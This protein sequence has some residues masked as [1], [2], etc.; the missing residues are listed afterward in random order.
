MLKARADAAL[1]DVRSRPEWSFVG[2]CDL[3]SLG[4][5][6]A[7]IAWQHWTERGMVRNES[8]ATE[9]SALGVDKDAPVIFIC[10]SGARSRAAAEAMHALGWRHCYN[11]SGGFEGDRDAVKHRGK[12]GG[13]KSAGLPW[14]QE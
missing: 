8:F 14:V 2:V 9:F 3:S 6:P 7:Q 12:T 10:R 11:L 5:K 13:W 4:R 1:V